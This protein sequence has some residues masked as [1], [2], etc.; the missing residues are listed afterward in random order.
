MEKGG[1]LKL[2]I[3]TDEIFTNLRKTF[4]YSLSSASSHT[5]ENKRVDEENELSKIRLVNLETF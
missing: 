3:L 5:L 2:I 4:S 1:I